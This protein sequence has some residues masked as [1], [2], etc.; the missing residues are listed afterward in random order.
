MQIAK[1]AGCEVIGIAG[2]PEK[3]AYVSSIGADHTIDYKAEDVAA[4]LAE[5][6]PDGVDL[7]FDNIGGPILDA[8][9][10]NMALEC[11]IVICGAMSQYDLE[12][13]RD[14]Y[15]VKNL[16]LL[17]FR[18]AR[19][20]GFVVPRFMHLQDEFDAQ[21]HELWDAGKIRQRSHIIEGIERAP[22]SVNMNLQ[23]R[24]EGKLMVRVAS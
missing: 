22:E 18:N 17:L 19:I 15:G 5:Y 1:A 12:D 9:L 11:R 8:V 6:C 10:V 24:N 21:L 23:G 2:G 20:E 3:C 16:Q 14:Q 7:F 4:K 13:P